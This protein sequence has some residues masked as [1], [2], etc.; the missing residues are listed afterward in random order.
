MLARSRRTSAHRERRH[1]SGTLPVSRVR[2]RVD[3]H[4][5]APTIR[6]Q[7]GVGGL[8]VPRTARAAPQNLARASTVGSSGPIARPPQLS[9]PRVA[10][11]LDLLKWMKSADS[12]DPKEGVFLLAIV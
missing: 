4:A 12:T 11:S 6:V 3:R 8:K 10:R 1:P 5:S 7:Q 9:V 2:A